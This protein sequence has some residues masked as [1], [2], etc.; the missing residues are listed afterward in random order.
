MYLRGRKLYKWKIENGKWK[1]SLSASL[2]IELLVRLSNNTE[3]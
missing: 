2:I 3:S 1:I